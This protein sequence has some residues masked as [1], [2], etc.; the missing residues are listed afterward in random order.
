MVLAECMELE[1]VCAEAQPEG[2]MVADTY[3]PGV[4]T[5]CSLAGAAGAEAA[6]PAVV[7]GNAAE[8]VVV[9]VVANAAVRNRSWHTEQIALKLP[10][11]SLPPIVLSIICPM[12]NLVFLPSS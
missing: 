12:C 6:Q 11:S 5:G 4:D 9:A 7:A 10:G 2:H 1:G 8:A 3:Q